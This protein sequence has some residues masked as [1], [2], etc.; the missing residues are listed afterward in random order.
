MPSEDLGGGGHICF[1][2]ISFLIDRFL[3]MQNLWWWKCHNLDKRETNVALNLNDDINTAN[4]M[5]SSSGLYASP[6]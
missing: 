2:M 3:H 5:V 6:T 4:E 1:A